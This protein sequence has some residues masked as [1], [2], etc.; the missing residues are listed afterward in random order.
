M[1]GESLARAVK[2]I[3][4]TVQKTLD[5]AIRLK[6]DVQMICCGD[7]GDA[8][9]SIILVSDA[10]LHPATCQASTTLTYF[11]FAYDN[12]FFR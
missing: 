6:I 8:T 11:L 7:D 9:L 2:R 4:Y 3:K 12:Q 10:L 1:Q 5:A